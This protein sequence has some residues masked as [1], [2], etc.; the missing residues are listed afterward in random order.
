MERQRNESQRERVI[1]VIIGS[2][3]E[4]RNPLVSELS[5]RPAECLS[6][7]ILATASLRMETS[8]VV[9]S[10][11]ERGRLREFEYGIRDCI[12]ATRRSISTDGGAG[13]AHVERQRAQ[14][15]C[16]RTATSG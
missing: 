4:D 9:V 8:V 11:Q 13:G 14:K 10:A 3:K 7:A 2:F 6:F 16:G 15:G 12:G 5:P 1:F